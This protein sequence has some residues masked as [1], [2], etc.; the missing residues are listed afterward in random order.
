MK[1]HFDLI[2]TIVNKGFA[3]EAMEAAKEAGAQGGHHYFRQRVGNP[4]SGKNSLVLASNRKGHCF[5]FSSPR[6]KKCY[7]ESDHSRC[8][9]LLPKEKGFLF[10]CQWMM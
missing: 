1:R 9:D 3:E 5:D 7:Y 6:R 4:R 10:R 8:R 2:L